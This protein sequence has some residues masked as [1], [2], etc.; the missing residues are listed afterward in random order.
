MNYYGK[1]QATLS[2][3]LA[4][5]PAI[6]V[7]E[8]EREINSFF[9]AYIFYKNK[10]NGRLYWTSCCLKEGYIGESRLRTDTELQFIQASHNERGICPFCGRAVTYKCT[11]RLGK[12]KNLIEYQPVVILKAEGGDI[13][14]RAYWA[15]KDYY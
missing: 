7:P 5:F 8:C 4:D 12:K 11:G 14:A 13:Y 6:N 10:G 2:G 15:C 9:K 3:E 1:L